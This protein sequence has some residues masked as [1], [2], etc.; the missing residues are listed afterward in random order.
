[1]PARESVTTMCAERLAVYTTIHPGCEPYLASWC[2]SVRRQS[3]RDFDLWIGLDA[4]TPAACPALAISPARL[5]AEV[6]DC[7]PV[8]WIVARPGDTPARL[9]QRA[10]AEMVT[11]YERIVFVDADDLLQHS[12]VAAAREALATCDVVGCALRLIDEQGVDMGVTFGLESCE[13]AERDPALLL[14]RVN[15]FGLSNSAYRTSVL[16]RCLPVPPDCVLTDWLLASRAFAL[17]ARLVWDRTPRMGYRQ[18][19]HNCTRIVPPF[20]PQ[21]VLTAASLVTRHYRLLLDNGWTWPAG[22]RRPFETA[23]GR[24]EAF[25]NVMRGA[26]ARLERY[27]AALNRLPPKYVWWW[28]VAHPDLEDLWTPSLSTAVSSARAHRHS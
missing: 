16:A 15:V 26:P 12:R 23:R 17:G 28:T 27:T 13:P 7:I 19:A 6:G 11:A 9:R 2:D 20:T 1:M 22:T 3:D 24:A 8:R 14:P 4:L 18:Y 21:D 5:E 25:Y 10:L